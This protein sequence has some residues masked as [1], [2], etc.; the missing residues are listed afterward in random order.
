MNVKDYIQY[1]FNQKYAV[2]VII[3]LPYQ[4]SISS[5]I[6]NYLWASFT[7]ILQFIVILL[8]S[9]GNTQNTRGIPNLVSWHLSHPYSLKWH[10]IRKQFP[11]A[12][13]I[14]PHLPDRSFASE[15]TIEWFWTNCCIFLIEPNLKK[16]S[17]KQLKSYEGTSFSG[18]LCPIWEKQEPFQKNH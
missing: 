6:K 5:K 7:Q 12:D 1:F 4:N 18:P 10:T 16:R 11:V 14:F 15:K 8:I 17:L 2:C 9:H 3:N 13:R